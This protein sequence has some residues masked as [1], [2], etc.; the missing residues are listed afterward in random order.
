M[1]DQE[2]LK[3][4]RERARRL[5]LSSFI[6]S[7]ISLVV[8]LVFLLAISETGLTKNRPEENDFLVTLLFM[9]I[10][11]SWSSSV[12]LSMAQAP[13]PE[14]VR[15]WQA[16]FILLSIFL[17]IFVSIAFVNPN[18]PTGLWWTVNF[19]LVAFSVLLSYLSDM[20]VAVASV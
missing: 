18:P 14:K 11:M 8:L 17:A 13:L 15:W 19:A 20:R 3:T 16:M 10:S 4:I 2:R 5:W 12:T 6:G 9:G 1:P 7:S